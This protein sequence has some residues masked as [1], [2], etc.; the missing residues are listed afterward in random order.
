VSFGQRLSEIFRAI[1]AAKFPPR[2]K[3]RYDLISEAVARPF[4]GTAG[5]GSIRAG[6]VTDEEKDKRD[7]R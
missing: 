4:G 2:P 7:E 3:T 1:S 5:R 6:G